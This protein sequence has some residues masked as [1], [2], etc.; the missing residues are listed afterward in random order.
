MTFEEMAK[1]RYSVKQFKNTPVEKEKLDKILEVAGLAPTARNAQSIR[2][3]VLQSE[4]ALEKANSLTRC[5]YGAP[6]CLMLAYNIDETYPYIEDKGLSSGDEDCS[7]VATHIMF[8]AMEQGL[9]SCW[10]NA[11]TPSKAK[12]LFGLPENEYVVLFMPIGYADAG[13]K[14]THTKKKPLDEI[15]KFL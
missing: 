15:V 7:I 13:P 4:E 11:F 3:Y 8:E 10:V 2:I 6:L 5:V 14:P 1:A 9:G 12:A